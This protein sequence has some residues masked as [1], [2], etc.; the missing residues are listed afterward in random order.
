MRQ[1][2]DSVAPSVHESAY[3]HPDATVIGDVTVE[4]DASVW[5]GAVLRGDEAPILTSSRP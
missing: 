4:A 1:A 5:P 2:V 3:V